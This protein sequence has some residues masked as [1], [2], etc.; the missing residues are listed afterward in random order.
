MRMVDTVECPSCGEDL[1]NIQSRVQSK[2]RDPSSWGWVD[3]N[4][5]GPSPLHAGDAVSDFRCLSCGY[6][7]SAEEFIT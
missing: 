3:S 1:S 2:S 7:G 6:E 5:E 4:P